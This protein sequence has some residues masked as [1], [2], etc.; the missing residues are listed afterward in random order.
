MMGLL[1]YL[2]RLLRTKS[3]NA[4]IAAEFEDWFDTVTSGMLCIHSDELN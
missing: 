4:T 3:I 2:L 1:T